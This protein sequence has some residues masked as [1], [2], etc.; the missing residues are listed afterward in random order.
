MYNGTP[1][2]AGGSVGLKSLHAGGIIAF[3]RNTRAVIEQWETE[4][5][6]RAKAEAENARRIEECVREDFGADDYDNLTPDHMH[7]LDFGETINPVR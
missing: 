3:A 7:G 6:R 5:A 4:V 2:I 1:A